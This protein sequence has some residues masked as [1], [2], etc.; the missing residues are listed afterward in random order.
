L[1]RSKYGAGGFGA[2]GYGTAT[3]NFFWSTTD[4]EHFQYAAIASDSDAVYAAGLGT[5]VAAVNQLSGSPTWRFD[6]QGSLVDSTPTIDTERLYVG[7]GS[8]TVYALGLDDG[9][10]E[11]TADI[12][13]AVASSPTVASGTVFVG[14][15]DGQICAIDA[16]SGAE[17]WSAVVGA[18]VYSAPATDG[19]TVYVTAADGTVA[20]LS[21]SDGDEIWSVAVTADTLRANPIV[22]TAGVVVA[23]SDL[24]L[25]DTETGD[26]LWTL[27]AAGS[28]ETT[29]LVAD[30]TIYATDESGILR[31]VAVD[32]GQ[33]DWT[34]TL[35]STVHATPLLNDGIL[36]V[37]TDDGDLVAIDP[38]T[39]TETDRWQLGGRIMTPTVVGSTI[40]APTW[41]GSIRVVAV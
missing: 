19:A 14:T 17:I 22:T 10:P 40:Y 36:Y 25:L 23:G 21:V 12:D 13:S 37:G 1:V 32:S 26:A 6:R 4:D 20:A 41:G 2:D 31:A 8:G 9:A 29:P 18:S 28:G 34:L 38:E 11:W 5:A 39:G 16:T 35:G 7:S 27:T 30:G 15:N 33:A 3:S 24:Q